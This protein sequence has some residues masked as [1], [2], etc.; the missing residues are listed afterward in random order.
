MVFEVQESL[1]VLILSIELTSIRPGT[2]FLLLFLMFTLLTLLTLL[3]VAL[4]LYK[5]FLLF[6]G[7]SMLPFELFLFALNLPGL[8][9]IYA[10]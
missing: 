5:L 3:L 8:F 2:L 9:L 1:L 6:L 10:I 4:F 7:L